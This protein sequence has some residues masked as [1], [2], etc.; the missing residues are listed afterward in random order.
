MVVASEQFAQWEPEVGWTMLVA[1]GARNGVEDLHA[2]RLIEDGQMPLFN[3]TVRRWLYEGFVAVRVVG[4][5]H[6]NRDWFEHYLNELVS[7][8]QDLMRATCIGATLAAVE[9]FTTAVGLDEP[10]AD[11]LVSA[12]AAGVDEYVD[13]IEGDDA[14][15]SA[16]LAMAA[17]MIPAEWEP[18][19]LSAEF[20]EQLGSA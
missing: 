6:A 19:E 1:L 17:L 10:D 11:A 16:R 7:D 5:E 18:P 12:A 15:S 20:R 4:E 9:E 2:A 8:E 3:R 14:D 13:L